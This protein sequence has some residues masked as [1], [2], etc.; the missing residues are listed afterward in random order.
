VACSLSCSFD[1]ARMAAM[2]MA[3]RLRYF[4]A[5]SVIV[6]FTSSHAC[7][8]SDAERIRA[9]EERVAQLER[10]VDSLAQTRDESQDDAARQLTASVARLETADAAIAAPPMFAAAQPSRPLPQELLPNLGKIGASAFLDAGL[11]SGPFSIGRGS[12]FGGGLSLPLSLVPGGRLQYEVTVA[13]SQNS[14]ELPVTSNVAQLIN[15]SVLNALYPMG[16]TT[17]IE[18]AFSGTGA[19]PFSVTV[20]ANWRV[21]TLQVVPLAL[22]YELTRW[23]RHRLRP[24]AVLGLGTYVTIS[25]QVTTGGI[26]QNAD[27]P[28]PTLA[29]LETLF[30]GNSPLSGA[31]VGGQIATAAELKQRGIPAGQGGIDVGFQ[32]GGGLEWR[33]GAGLSTAIDSRYNYAPGGTSYNE[34][35]SRIGW[36]F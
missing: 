2:K 1:V 27:L 18:Q 8:Q 9:L 11:N 25:N 10:M 12:F 30:A 4:F 7:A 36:H 19:A 20:P 34:T 5:L 3:E 6:A 35:I 23:D 33:L 21:Q 15:L 14:R 17:N 29:L 24:Y 13:L 22:R 31:L 16:G 28:A 32:V 26:R